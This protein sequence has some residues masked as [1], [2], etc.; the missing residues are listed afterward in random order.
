VFNLLNEH[1]VNG[2][3]FNDTGSPDYA[4]Y[5]ETVAAQLYDPSRFFQPRRIEFGI[6]LRSL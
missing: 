4:L 1:F 5:P 3:V 2:F 6:S